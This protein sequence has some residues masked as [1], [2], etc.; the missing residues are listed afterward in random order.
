MGRAVSPPDFQCRTNIIGLGRSERQQRNP[1]CVNNKI[2]SGREARGERA[3]RP[4][5]PKPPVGSGDRTTSIFG[6]PQ[7]EFLVKKANQRDILFCD[8]D[9]LTNKCRRAKSGI[10]DQARNHRDPKVGR[11][12]QW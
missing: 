12:D 8:A 9:E 4:G 6:L 2:K 11:V 5:G 3:S 1:F 7:R 10:E